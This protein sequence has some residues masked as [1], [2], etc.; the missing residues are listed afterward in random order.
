MPFPIIP[1][2]ATAAAAGLGYLL[3]GTK[4][5]GKATPQSPAVNPNTPTPYTPPKAPDVPRQYAP[6]PLPDMKPIPRPAD[7]PPPVPDYVPPAPAPIPI[8]NFVPP[9]PAPI[10]VPPTPNK[11]AGKW[12]IQTGE[13]VWLR[14]A[15][16]VATNTQVATFHKGTKWQL[17][18]GV[19]TPP[20]SSAPMGF[21]KVTGPGGYGYMAAKYLSYSSPPAPSP[22]PSP[23]PLPTPIVPS[24]DTATVTAPSGLNLRSSASTS[25][26]VL[27][28]MTLGTK[29]KLLDPSPTAPTDGA[30]NG[31]YHVLAPNGMTGYA[32]AQWL[33]PDSQPAPPGPSPLPLPNP[34][35]AP[36]PI[37]P[38]SLTATVH[39]SPGANLRSTPSTSGTVLAGVFV[40]ST[41]TIINPVPAAPSTG[42]DQGWYNVQTTSGQTGWI[43]AH[44]LSLNSPISTSMSAHGEEVANPYSLASTM[45]KHRITG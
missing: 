13:G 16:E 44:L 8:P 15:Q 41:V 43:A 34:L 26:A 45:R 19:R 29:V 28:G 3:F 30:P 18:D 36:S 9:A 4:D 35:P 31:W 1:V 7:L 24:G 25:G 5:A 27:Y 10:P 40:G 6:I 33:Q 20:T 22:S 23:L 2:A 42:A 39:A 11:D 21:L 37:I 38:S 14:T 12:M 17:V 32:S